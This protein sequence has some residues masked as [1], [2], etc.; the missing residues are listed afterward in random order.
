MAAISFATK[1]FHKASLLEIAQ[2][3]GIT[4][5]GL[6]HHFKTKEN[7]LTELL[8]QRDANDIAEASIPARPHGLDFLQHLVDTVAR[9]TERVGITQL[10][11]VLSADGVTDEHPAQE[12]FRSRYEGLRELIVEALVEA[13][14]VGDIG[15]DVDPHAAAVSM[16]AVMDGLQIQWLYAP[17]SVDMPALTASVINAL[18]S[19]KRPVVKRPLSP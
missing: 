7:L 16:I 1:G 8:R 4:P 19:P 6:L 5:A 17:D 12:W 13:Q 15:G 9:N 10:Y 3:A 2:Q 18:V 11:V 14:E